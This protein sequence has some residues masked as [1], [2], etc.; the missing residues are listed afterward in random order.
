[1]SYAENAANGDLEQGLDVLTRHFAF[2][3]FLKGSSPSITA[4]TTPSCVFLSSMRL[5]TRFSMKI[6]SRVLA[7]SRSRRWPSSTFSSRRSSSR[8]VGVV[9]EHVGH[10]HGDRLVSL[11]TRRLTVVDTSQSVNA[12]SASTVSCVCTPRARWISISTC[13]R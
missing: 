11:I 8:C 12:Y 13:S 2:D 6:C 3:V 7:W 4:L 10:A 1:M 9:L 5:Y